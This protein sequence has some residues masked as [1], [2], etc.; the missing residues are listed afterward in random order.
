MDYIKTFL[1]FESKNEIENLLQDFLDSEFDDPIKVKPCSLTA[2][3]EHSMCSYCGSLNTS[4]YRQ[5]DNEYFGGGES[6][7]QCHDCDAT[8][9]VFDVSGIEIDLNLYDT[10]GKCF[11]TINRNNKVGQ[12]YRDLNK[13]TKEQ[14]IRLNHI[15]LPFGY[16]YYRIQ[17]SDEIESFITTPEYMNNVLSQIVEEDMPKNEKDL[18]VITRFIY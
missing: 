7:Y 5:P 2:Y 6:A 17:N 16:K 11:T 12:E 10:D 15:L 9:P 4:E 13:L 8:S 14:V 3:I 1:L 18:E